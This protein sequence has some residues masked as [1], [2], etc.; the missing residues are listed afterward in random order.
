MKGCSNDGPD[1]RASS[2]RAYP[3]GQHLSTPPGVPRNRVSHGQSHHLWISASQ[4]DQ[5]LL[6]QVPEAPGLGIKIF[7]WG[8]KLHWFEDRWSRC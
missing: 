8:L 4:R 6:H 2:P 5:M 7:P 1:L 3:R